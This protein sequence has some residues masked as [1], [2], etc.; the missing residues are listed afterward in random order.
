[1]GALANRMYPLAEH[2]RDAGF[3]VSVATGM[4]NYPAGVVFPGYRGIRFLAEDIDGVR[5]L[6]RRSYT[7]ARNVSARAQARAYASFLPAV[8]ESAMRAGPVDVIFV[9]SPPLFPALPSIAASILRRAKLILDLRDLWPDEIIACGAADEG[10]L[11]VLA[12]RGL[13]RLSYRYADRIACTT[14]AF[15]DTVVSRGVP[16]SKTFLLP[17]GADLALFRPLPRENR[18]SEKYDFGDRFVV[19]YSGLMGIKHD[20]DVLLDAA[21]E[22]RRDRPDVLFF[23]RG[24]GP[25]EAHLRH[26]AARRGLENVRFGG[27]LEIEDVPYALARADAC[28]TSL[29][30]DP[31][32]D[33][34]ISVK[35]FEY[36]ACGKP[37]IAALG[38]EG[39]RVVNEGD[40]GIVVPPGD[41]A[42]I[43]DAVRRMASDPESARRMGESGLRHVQQHY[44]RA[45]TA[46]RLERVVRELCG[47]PVEV[48]DVGMQ[49]G[50]RDHRPV[51]GGASA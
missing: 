10:S 47:L 21:E 22:L 49:A 3:R 16:R 32:L 40:A 9:T 44:S 48:G 30:P 7:T 19:M 46:E 51:A 25:R 1:M 12:T 13:E 35:I 27:E 39:A 38:G 2:L 24:G 18:I 23:L 36:M 26:E 11:P 4:P 20:L 31:Y 50:A 15:A 41:G 5:V 8:F 45:R 6:R 37:V 14:P 28:V 17:N 29:L 43:A 34:I 42:A 33:K